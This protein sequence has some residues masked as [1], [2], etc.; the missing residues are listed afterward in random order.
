M[1]VRPFCF[2]FFSGIAGVNAG[3]WSS[4]VLLES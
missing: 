4:E 2:H 1:I 3:S